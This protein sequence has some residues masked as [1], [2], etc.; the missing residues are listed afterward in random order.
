MLD[1]P[2]RRADRADAG[3]ERVAGEI[4]AAGQRRAR[5]R[6]Q[7]RLELDVI[8]RRDV[9]RVAGRHPD[10]ARNLLLRHAVGARRRR[11][12][13]ARRRSSSRLPRQS[14]AGRR[15]GCG[16]A[17]ARRPA[18]CAAT[19]TGNPRTAPRWRARGRERAAGRE[20]THASAPKSADH[21]GRQPHDRLAVG[22]E[23]ERD[24]RPSPRPGSIRKSAA[25]RPRAR[26]RSRT[27]C[28]S[29]APTRPRG[30]SRPPRRERQ[31]GQEWPSG[32]QTNASADAGESR[33]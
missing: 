29:P 18:P 19:S 12:P 31:C 25:P 27:R 8:A 3:E 22:G 2:Q 24:A 10:A 9:G 28:A 17:P 4:V 32:G 14:L 6:Q 30:S 33:I 15:C 13:C 21:Q 20:H 11:S 23:I 26:A 16:R 1:R 7:A 5:G